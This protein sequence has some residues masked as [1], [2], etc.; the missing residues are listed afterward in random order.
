MEK[1]LLQ[2]ERRYINKQKNNN[3]NLMK[4][5]SELD[6]YLRPEKSIQERKENMI[7]F[8][9]SNLIQK[10]IQNLNPLDLNFKILKK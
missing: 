1:R 9:D 8:Y 4:K 3:D 6:N 5:V 10:L 2:I 7:S